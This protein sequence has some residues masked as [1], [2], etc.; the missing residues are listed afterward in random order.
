VPLPPEKP[1]HPVNGGRFGFNETLRWTPASIKGD[2]PVDNYEIYI[3]SRQDLAWPVMPNT[4]RITYSDKPTF[5]L[6]FPDVLRHDATYHWRV[7]GR[8]RE[9]VWGDW[10][11]TWSFVANGPNPPTRLKAQHENDKI[12]LTWESPSG[13]TPVDHYEVYGSGEPGFSPLRKDEKALVFKAAVSRPAN[14]LGTTHSTEW[15]CTLSSACFYRITAVD[16]NGNRSTPTPIAELPTPTLLPI[17]LPNAEVGHAYDVTVPARYRTGRYAWALRKGLITDLADTPHYALHDKGGAN[18][19]AIDPATGHLT[20][21]PSKPGN[22]SIVVEV[23][24]EKNQRAQQTY[25][26]S[27]VEK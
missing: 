21:T 16:R 13:G 20:G 11:D 2:A 23:Q 17:Q 24:T 25:Q 7:R 27:V 5:A 10:S 3:S 12:I 9:G 1:I 26:I 8:S 22:Y 15:D 14:L 19:L 6:V 4:H 18:W